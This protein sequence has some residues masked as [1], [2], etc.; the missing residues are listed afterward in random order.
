MLL[1]VECLR[2]QARAAQFGITSNVDLLPTDTVTG[3]STRKLRA[4][5][6]VVSSPRSVSGNARLFTIRTSRNLSTA[7]L[8]KDTLVRSC[9][10]LL[11]K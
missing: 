2:L 7:D 3:L 9:V 4:P 11:N 1:I 8:S 5:L 6:S 10:G